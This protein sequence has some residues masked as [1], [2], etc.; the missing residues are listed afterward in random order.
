[1]SRLDAILENKREELARV[2]AAR[3][4]AALREAASSAPP[5]LDFIGAVRRAGAPVSAGAAAT[6]S[7]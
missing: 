3:P 7:A 6:N 5:S 4:L 2:K 1:M